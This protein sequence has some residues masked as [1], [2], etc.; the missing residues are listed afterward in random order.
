MSLIFIR[1]FNN[2]YIVNT[3]QDRLRDNMGIIF[4][5]A[6]RL[7][8]QRVVTVANSNGTIKYTEYFSNNNI[9]VCKKDDVVEQRNLT[10][11]EQHIYDRLSTG[12]KLLKADR[13]Y[14]LDNFLI[15]SD[16]NR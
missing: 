4:G 3:S 15:T 12:R 6:I 9:Q 5:R 14:L 13:H 16:S 10:E 8:A 1:T 11:Q 2:A 7:Y